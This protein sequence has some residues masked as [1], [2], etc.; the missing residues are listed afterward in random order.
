MFRCIV[1]EIFSLGGGHALSGGVTRAAAWM[2]AVVACVLL[3][4]WTPWALLAMV[5]VRLASLVEA[6]RRGRR[7][8]AG[9]QW[10][11]KA[12]IVFLV[13]SYGF[14]GVTRV[15]VLEAFKIPS[16]SMSPTL[17][18][19]DHVI[20]DKLSLMWR[21]PARA[22]VV[23]FRIGG[24]DFVG[25]IVAVGGDE[26][27]VRGGV[28][29]LNGA[30]LPQKSLGEG[31][32]VT[33]AD[34]QKGRNIREHARAAEETLGGHRYRILFIHDSEDPF[35]DFPNAER[36]GCGVG[37]RYGIERFAGKDLEPG[38]DAMTCRVPPGMIFILGDNRDNSNDSRDRGV[39]P[40]SSV[41]ARVVGIW[42]P[43]GRAGGIQ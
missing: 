1:A 33:S 21:A 29:Q 9:G 41:R 8:P 6:G 13:V 20:G 17:I 22:E 31:E 14:L 34:E 26:I 23:V 28:V 42:T 38:R 16:P 3:A 27:A 35:T 36:G 11:W 30:P 7:G 32:Y 19:G 25:R 40:A 15:A 18:V 39:F 10:H 12:M 2:A 5:V 37:S 4:L 24:I 43:L